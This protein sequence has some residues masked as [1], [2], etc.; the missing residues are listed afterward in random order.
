MS[1]TDRGNYSANGPFRV[2]ADRS[3]SMVDIIEVFTS[4]FD[5]P[6]LVETAKEIVS[7]PP[8]ERFTRSVAEFKELLTDSEGEPSEQVEERLSGVDKDVVMP[9]LLNVV[10]DM[11]GTLETSIIEGVL[12][13]RN[14]SRGYVVLGL[15]FAETRRAFSDLSHYEDSDDFEVLLSTVIALYSRILLIAFREQTEVNEDML[16]DV[17]RADYYRNK[18]IYGQTGDNPEE[19]PLETVEKKVLL[20]GAVLAYSKLDITVSRGAELAN[21]STDEFETTLVENGIRPRYGPASEEEL[22]GDESWLT[23]TEANE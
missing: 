13:D 10:Q 11:L 12:T 23:T 19:L 6:D 5:L 20:D 9:R 3:Q 2:V 1:A 22:F 4:I 7:L 16:R 14:E 18:V 17:V 15:Y 8:E 21:V